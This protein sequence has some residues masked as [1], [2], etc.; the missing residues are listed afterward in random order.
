MSINWNNIGSVEGQEEA[1]E[2]LV[3][4]LAGKEEIKSAQRFIRIG[5]PDGGKECFWETLDNSIHCWQAKFFTR[6]LKSPEWKQIEKSTKNT[7]DNHPNLVEYIIAIPVD[8]PDGKAKGRSMLTKWDEFASKWERYAK[9]KGMYI[10][11]RYWGKSQLETRLIK[12]QNE[13]LRYYFF[14]QDEFKDDWFAK[15]NQESFDALGGRYTPHL[16]FELP[17][18]KSFDG[19]ER[20]ER[21]VS[22]LDGRYSELLD[23][24]RSVRVNVQNGDV[25]VGIKSLKASIEQFCAIYESIEF[26][27]I[28]PIPF[29]SIENGLSSIKGLVGQIKNVLQK[30]TAEKEKNKESKDSYDRLFN[31]ELHDLRELAY[32]CDRFIGF[33][34][35]V[36]CKTANNPNLILLGPAGQGKSH[37]LADIVEE[38][39]K[40]GLC[41]LLLLGENFVSDE[42]PWTQI[43]SNQLRFNKIEE[44]FLGALNAKAESVQTRLFVIIDAL[45]EGN[46]RKVWPKKLRSFIRS[47]EEYPWLALVV[48]IRT[49]FDKLIAPKEKIDEL[50]APRV[51]HTGFEGIEYEA[52]KH[53][54]KYYNIT[55][56]G[57]PLL[58][59]EF[60]NPLFLKLFCEGLA[61]RGLTEVPDGYEG[62]SM[63]IKHFLQSVEEKLA[64]PDQLDYDAKLRLMQKSIDGILVE[65]LETN[66]DHVTYEKGDEIVN[67]YFRGKCGSSDTQYLKRLISENVLNENLYWKKK[68]QYY[69]GIHFAYQ[70]FQDHLMVA[71]LLDKHLDEESPITSFAS[72]V[73]REII[74]N[75]R[76]QYFDQNLIEALSIQV[77]ERTGM[78]LHE[79]APYAAQSYSVAHAFIDGLIWRRSDTI[80]ENSR[81]YVNEVL[82]RNDNLFYRFLD[83][84]LSLA[85]RPDFFFNADMLHEVLFKRELAER[86]A[87]WTTW[88]QNKYGEEVGSNSVKRLIDWAW[89]ESNKKGLTE[90][91]ARL[92]AILLSWFLTSSNRHLRDGASNGLVCLLQDRIPTLIKVLKQFEGVNDPYVF[93]RLYGV[94]YGCALRSNDKEGLLALSQYVY[95]YIFD[96]K[97]EVYRNILLRDYARGIIEYALH[98]KLDLS[99]DEEMFRPPYTSNLPDRLPTTGE[100]DEKYDPKGD[101]G[102]YRGKKWGAT[103]ILSSMTTEYGRGTGGYGDFGRYVFQRGLSSWD[104]DPDKLSN[105][106]VQMIFELGYDPEVFSDFDSRQ[107]SG[108]GS[109][110]L[111]RIGKKYQW[112]VFYNLLS[113]VADTIDI[114]DESNYSGTKIP[115]SYDGPWSPYVRDYDPTVVI[116]KTQKNSNV[117]ECGEVWWLN[118]PYSIPG[119]DFENWMKQDDFPKVEDSLIVTD[120]KGVEWVNLDM[121]P[122]WVEPRKRGEENWGR[123]KKRVWLDVSSMLIKP[124]QLNKVLKVGC[125]ESEQNWWGLSS[126]PSSHYEIFSREYFW[127]PGW[128]FFEVN[129]S[130]GGDAMPITLEDPDS[131][132]KIAEGFRTCVTYNWEEEF[133]CSKEESITYLKPSGIMAMGLKASR[134]EGVYEN[135]DGEIVCFDPSVYEK[136]PSCLLVR[137][138]H[139]LKLLKES[140]YKLFWNVKAEKQI[141]GGSMP[142]TLNFDHRLAGLYHLDKNGVFE[143]ETKTF[144][145]KYPS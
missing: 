36:P 130:W 98:L 41:S 70:R 51:R 37:T 82:G 117:L 39:Q 59:P 14:N 54:F 84:S 145:G 111:E 91:S 42:Q 144:I 124:G 47:F 87:F 94:A 72:G 105:L 27:G 63:I 65:I 19:L 115:V 125:S 135:K 34:D 126:E 90:E 33:L 45:N 104:I 89:D 11:I 46:G 57:S 119:T 3:C 17:L 49:P 116:A 18:S 68:G 75:Q 106:A 64:E 56:P 9:A 128:W 86:D 38:R 8:P 48:S 131:G 141:L 107:G 114:P 13:G 58:H 40:R 55:P 92:A 22:Q 127:S 136:G 7:I 26:T 23:K 81:K 143:G 102:S 142:R 69:D 129:T 96:V 121:H 93:E 138:D 28:K 73:L 20:G 1:F 97:G 5:K 99:A 132:K 6:S 24:Y 134:K 120:S 100:I 15:K 2:E 103:A 80:G 21:F 16:N 77:P 4:Q 110:H 109:G 122:D 50:V 85:I 67:S 78:E 25:Q 76:H 29:D 71:A 79:V 62:I 32:E 53:F 118:T 66:S 140:E 139:L 137:K 112:I 30:L 74:E 31:D 133:D 44:V 101:D 35:S 61:L 123:T 95:S 43:L 108:R 113:L 60:Q 83:T 52:S 10:K 12:P 88:L